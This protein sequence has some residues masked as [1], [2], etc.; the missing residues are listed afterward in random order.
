M[1]RR[2]FLISG[3]LLTSSLLLANR[4]IHALPLTDLS[5]A[6]IKPRKITPGDT[7][8]LIAPAG[9]INEDM[10]EESKKNLEE[11]GFKTYHTERIL[12]Q[13]GYL[14]G[15]DQ[16]R[17]DDLN[18]MFGN[19]N[20]DAIV[21]VRGGYGCA[22]M[23]DMVDYDLIRNNPKILIGYSDLTSLLYAVYAKTGLVC[24]H[25]PVGTSTFNEFSVNYF[26]KNLMEV[27][28]KIIMESDKEAYESTDSEYL[29]NVINSGKAT[30][31]LVGG[32]LSLVASLV[33]TKYDIDLNGKILFLEEVGE[34][35]Y[36]IDRMLT[37]ME[38]AG[39][40]D[41]I[42]G[43]AIGVFKNCEIKDEEERKHSFTLRELL[44]DRL[45][46][47]NV[48]AIYGLSF[49]HTVNKFTLPFG[50]KAELNVNNRTLTLLE[51]PVI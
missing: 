2:K 28:N 3:S 18:H 13:N 12:K 19:D 22:R 30:G 50:I 20:V 45:K 11:L 24:F 48:P 9:N 31:E 35:P 38:L 44:G 14:A 21:A 8:G 37:Q 40:F 7:I 25:G 33:G 5:P 17:A 15:S 39:K 46:K 16:N 6:K 41:N 51:S 23:L 36:R 1:D 4:K 10:L 32:N 27:N 42:A 43:F 26:K 34:D 49:G 47:Y 29:F